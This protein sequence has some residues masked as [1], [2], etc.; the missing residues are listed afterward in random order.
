MLSVVCVYNNEKILNDILLKSLESQKVDYELILLD[1]TGGHFKSAASAL[2]Y[3]GAKATGD[4]IMFIHQDMWLYSDSW[5]EDTERHLNTIPDLGIA[6]VLGNVGIEG[7]MHGKEN[8]KF[9]I[10][11][12]EDMFKDFKP[13]EHPE[14]VES[15]DECLLIVPREV[16]NK[17]KFDEIVFDGWDCYAPDYCLEIKKLGLKSYVIPG[18]SSHCCL[19]RNYMIWEF[20]DLLKYHRRLYQK[21]KKD[22][23]TI[24]TLMETITG[25]NLHLRALKRLVAPWYYRIFPKVPMMIKKEL[26]S[27][28]TTLDLG[29]GSF[30][31]LSYCDIPMTVGVDIS[32]PALI[33]SKNHRALDHH[34]LGD[35]R[36]I[37]FKPKSF[38]AVIALNVF[39]N[40]TKEEGIHLIRNMELLAKKKVIMTFRNYP[41][42]RDRENRN[43]VQKHHA[44]NWSPSD[45]R[46]M[47]Y[48]VKGYYEDEDMEKKYKFPLDVIDIVLK[49]TIYCAPEQT[50]SMM[51]IKEINQSSNVNNDQI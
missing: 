9:S 48:Q 17:L 32:Y 14:K 42:P 38:D 37:N 28:E 15:L 27:C 49:K 10:T 33:E 35:I 23:K 41:F 1:N 6:G 21:H 2:N 44:S 12:F 34:I 19:R 29:C 18:R 11:M 31:R 39:E 26:K 45:F 51:M 40:L 8:L 22:Y 3:G 25:H 50:P 30:S 46:K 20:K 4:Y 5:I 43:P 13:V 16:F 24:H 7:P 47:G 36:S